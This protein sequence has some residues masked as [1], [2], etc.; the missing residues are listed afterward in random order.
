[1]TKEDRTE[2]ERQMSLELAR[3]VAFQAIGAEAGKTMKECPACGC[4]PSNA[5]AYD[6]LRKEHEHTKLELARNAGRAATFEAEIN[7]MKQ[8]RK[9]RPGWLESKMRR[10]SQALARLYLEVDYLRNELRRKQIDPEAE[11]EA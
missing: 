4:N 10:Q 6:K 3:K 2:A 9:A 1:M 11:E 8:E 5:L 7:F